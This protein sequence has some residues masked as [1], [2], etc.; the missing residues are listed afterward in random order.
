MTRPL[1]LAI[2]NHRKVDITSGQGF[3]QASGEYPTKGPQENRS[4]NDGHSA[5]APQT[6]L[7]S[8]VLLLGSKSFPFLSMTNLVKFTIFP[9]VYF[10]APVVSCF[11]EKAAKFKQE[12]LNCTALNCFPFNVKVLPISFSAKFS[13]IYYERI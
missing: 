12:F 10:L 4:Y 7:N 3:L 8:A 11:S 1:V 5:F 6:A 2:R 13:K 9:F